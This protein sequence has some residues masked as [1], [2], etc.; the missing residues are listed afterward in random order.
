MVQPLV[1]HRVHES[2]GHFAAYEK[3][4]DCDSA[5]DNTDI[6]YGRPELLV[7]DIRR[8]TEVIIKQDKSLRPEHVD[9]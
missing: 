9:T 4:I 6:L 3:Y 5:T 8:F 1:Y 7:N 2:G